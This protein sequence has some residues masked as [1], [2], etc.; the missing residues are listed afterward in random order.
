MKTVEE[1]LLRA[2][3]SFKGQA[4]EWY[5]DFKGH[6][7]EQVL[8]DGEG[9]YFCERCDEESKTEG[10]CDGCHKKDLD[11]EGD[12]TAD[13]KWFCEPCNKTC[14]LCDKTWDCPSEVQAVPC[15]TCTR[16]VC[17]DC[18]DQQVADKLLDPEAPFICCDGE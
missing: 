8:H 4:T 12:F 14:L 9:G 2:R 16:S 13:G 17:G 3:A 6:E 7:Q 5:C 10:D 18:Y 15:E 1:M 11:C